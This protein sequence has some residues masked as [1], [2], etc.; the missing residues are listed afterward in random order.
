MADCFKCGGAMP[1]KMTLGCQ[2]GDVDAQTLYPP[3]SQYGRATGRYYPRA[4]RQG[5]VMCVDPR[6]L[7]VSSDL[8][9]AV[10]VVSA[11]LQEAGLV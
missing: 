8:W 4:Y 5:Q 3:Q 7:A 2:S 10:E 1:D 9:K 6:D 11:A